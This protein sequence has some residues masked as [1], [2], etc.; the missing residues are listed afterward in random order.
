MN[1]VLVSIHIEPSS[2]AVPLGTA[3]IAAAAK[4]ALGN[5]VAVTLVDCTLQQSAAECTSAILE[6]GPEAVGLSISVWNRDL[7]LD[8]ARRL[9]A[10]APN[11]VLF[12]GGPEVT[13]DFQDLA[14]H[15]ELDFVLTGEGENKLVAALTSLL[16]GELPDG[17]RGAPL[18]SPV[19]LSDLPSPYLS[20]ILQPIRNGGALWEL[21]RGCPYRCDFCFESRGSAIV[22]R[23]PLQRV[24]A[25][26]ELFAACGVSEVFV[27][28]PTFNYDKNAAKELLF[29]MA[30]HGHGLRF[31][32]E[33]RAEL[34][35]AELA[36]LFAAIDCSLQIGLQSADTEVLKL[37]NRDFDREE[38]S[39][40]VLLL[41][42][43][44]VSYGFDL[45][46]GLPGDSLEGFL[47]SL[48]FALGLRPNH[49]DIFPLAVLPGTR[50]A[51]T[52]AGLGLEYQR[53]NPYRVLSSATFSVCDMTQA[54]R[55]AAACDFFYNRGRAVPWF[56]LVLENLDLLPS[57]FLSL[58]AENMSEP[59]PEDPVKLQQRFVHDQ[60]LQRQQ[61]GVAALA[62]DLLAYF[63]YAEALCESPEPIDRGAATPNDLQ[64]SPAACFITFDHD[65]Q[66]LQEHFA[67][68]ITDLEELAFF[69]PKVDAEYLCWRFEGELH[70]YPPSPAESSYLKSLATADPAAAPTAN[71]VTE[72]LSAGILCRKG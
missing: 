38:F 37:I 46:Y 24:Q 53:H 25:E 70:F 43:A 57:E 11:M 16:R 3:T 44:G 9:K 61:P 26:L 7:A 27:L 19:D 15:E 28:D 64:L 30:K 67:A 71:F 52:A 12:A 69:V 72:A 29:L 36:D 8:I 1:L 65:P 40:K 45:I 62:G 47:S 14:Q 41:H 35:D 54:A 17:S 2:R 10:V 60:F 68:G 59:F 39:D 55:I 20:G 48:D 4:M 23:F 32:L 58:F 31:S 63:G 22:R 21:S 49:L 56:T 51:E 18:D 42:E 13:A 66:Q 33:I 34:V 6:H 50:L 5:K